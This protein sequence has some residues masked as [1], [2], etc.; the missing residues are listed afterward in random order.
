M[1]P[2]HPAAAAA[3]SANRYCS[4]G[5]P[6]HT[7]S[8][9]HGRARRICLRS[10]Q[11]PLSPAKCTRLQLPAAIDDLQAPAH[12]RQH[13][14]SMLARAN[15]G[16]SRVARLRL[17]RWSRSVAR[18]SPR[19]RKCSLG[20]T[21]LCRQAVLRPWW[22]QL[23]LLAPTTRTL[24]PGRSSLVSWHCLPVAFRE[25]RQLRPLES[26]RV[27]LHGVFAFTGELGVTTRCWS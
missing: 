5:A 17:S 12:R 14:R 10:L 19:H 1:G 27:H 21:V 16:S 2:A 8:A 15:H 20:S 24:A 18:A 9:C 23:Q 4:W 11:P 22:D 25:S 26:D 6:T 7:A 3:A 13:V